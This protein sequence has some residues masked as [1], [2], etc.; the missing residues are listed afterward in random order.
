M[1]IGVSFNCYYGLDIETQI[2]LMK[3]NG[4]EASFIGSENEF[5]DQVVKRLK[6]EN[7]FCENLHGPCSIETSNVNDMWR[8]SESSEEMFSRIMRSVEKGGEHEIPGLV[9]HVTA[10]PK[11]P[12]PTE[13]GYE[14]F[15]K[16]F[17][18]AKELGV[19]IS[20][21]NIRP[22]G[23]LAFM[24][25]QFPDAGFCWDTGHEA[26][27]SKNVQF[28]PIFGSRLKALHIH[29]NMLEHDDH[30]IPGD[31]NIDFDRVARQIAESPYEGS[32]MLELSTRL[33][34]AYENVAPEE[35]YARAAKAGRELSAKIEAIRN[36]NK[37]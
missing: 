13:R 35:F 6:E 21:E 17:E 20:C 7:I 28:M 2:A 10:G 8:N 11:P 37:N 16:V 14:R 27:A 12:R 36:G 4:F 9:L 32:V 31:G 5:V 33:C 34:N 26:Y 22:Y 25:E 1:K 3:K 18:R 24:I 30:M 15:V 19:Q 23:N 29:D